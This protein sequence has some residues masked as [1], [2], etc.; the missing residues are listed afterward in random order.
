MIGSRRAA[1]RAAREGGSAVVFA[2]RG[3]PVLIEIG[4]FVFCLIDAIQTPAEDARNLAKGLW[5]LLIVVVPIVG[6]VAWLV[7]GRPQRTGRS[8]ATPGFPEYERVRRGPLAPD[9]DPAFLATLR[10]VDRE[11]EETLNRWEA[12]LRRRE[13]ELRR[14]DEGDEPPG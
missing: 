14:R 7:A 12:D 9:D 4:L 6:S 5:I 8:F 2:L 13:D 10:Q 11:H 3:L 1:G